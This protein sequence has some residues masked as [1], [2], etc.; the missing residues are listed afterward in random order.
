MY[1][2]HIP[3]NFSCCGILPTTFNGEAPLFACIQYAYFDLGHNG[4]YNL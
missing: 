1:N 2:V 3:K 4:H